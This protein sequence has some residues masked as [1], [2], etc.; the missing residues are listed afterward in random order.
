VGGVGGVAERQTCDQAQ[1]A[2]VYMQV[3]NGVLT[4]PYNIT[5]SWT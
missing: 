3:L 1:P 5:T 2:G 4:A